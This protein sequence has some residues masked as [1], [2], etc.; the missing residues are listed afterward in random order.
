MGLLGLE[1]LVDRRP[2]NLSTGEAQRVALARALA[3]S[4]E[5]LLLDEPL[6]ALDLSL[7]GR[8]LRYLK[9]VYRELGI[10]MVYVSHNISEVLAIADRTLVISRGRQLAFDHPRKVLLNPFVHSLVEA[11]SLENLLEVTVSGRGPGN[12]L[13]G[14]R[15]G[16]S[17]LW[18]PAV[19]P[20]GG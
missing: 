5:L 1:A 11:G 2:V 7:R 20:P 14:A 15:L 8:V 10:P 16:D 4:P 6:A 17:T 12:S 13:V 19:P 18:I 3:T 9:D